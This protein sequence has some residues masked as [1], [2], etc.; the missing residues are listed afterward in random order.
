MV[1]SI[2]P[3]EE[4]DEAAIAR[5]WAALTAYHVALDPRL[6]DAVPGASADY[7]ARL[8]ERRDDPD[9]RTFVAETDGQVIGYVLGAVVDLHPDLFQHVD[10]GFIA[11][12][13]VD[14]GYRGQGVARRLVMAINQWFASVGVDHVEWQVAAKNDV[15]R[16]FWEAV[17]GQPVMVRMR[18]ELAGQDRESS[19]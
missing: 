2:R 8:V 15:G 9:T 4:R 1:V 12:I 16:K 19:A 5:L 7:A 3:V 14:P 6:P 13:F 18:M 11:D 10:V 17:G